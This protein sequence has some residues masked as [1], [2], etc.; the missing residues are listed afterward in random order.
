MQIHKVDFKAF[1]YIRVSKEEED[2]ENQKLAIKK[3]AEENN[4]KIIDFIDDPDVSGWKVPILDRDGFKELMQ[5]IKEEG[6][7]TIVIY[8]ITRFGRNWKDVESTY[9]YL[10][11]KGIKIYFVM[12]PFLNK[13][14]FAQIF[15]Q[16]KEPLR[17]YL[18]DKI[19][20]DTF[21]IFASFAELESVMI[22]MRTRVGL[23]K[24]KL[25]GSQIGA[26]RKITD[27]MME[28]VAKMRRKGYSWRALAQLVKER[29]GIEVSHTALMM[30]YKDWKSKKGGLNTGVE[31]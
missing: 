7:N 12:Q 3:F 22:S 14:F 1:A 23:E 5:R 30:N 10:E 8:D 13:D 18:I 29:Y 28:Y 21:H 6:I 17:S 19:F 16:M 11:E 27:E 9:Q 26:E 15:S 25:K 20:Y 31:S 2:I 4:I 24:A